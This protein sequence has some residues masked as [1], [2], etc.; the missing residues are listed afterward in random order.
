MLRCECP[1]EGVKN[2]SMRGW[3]DQKNEWPFVKHKPGQ[4]RCT[5][6][7]KLYERDG[8]RLW[9]CSNCYMSGD[10]EVSQ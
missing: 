6:E 9:L 2:I 8:K 7:I 4:C 5:N 1:E 10:R 3:Y